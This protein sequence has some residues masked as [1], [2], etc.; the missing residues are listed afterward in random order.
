MNNMRSTP[1]RKSN[2]IARLAGQQGARPPTGNQEGVEKSATGRNSSQPNEEDH[3]LTETTSQTGRPS[4]TN[5]SVTSKGTRVRWTRDEYRDVMRTYYTAIHHPSNGP[6]T[7]NAYLIWRKTNPNTRLN[8][9]ENKL[10][11]QR[12]YIMNKKIFTED[13]LKEIEDSVKNDVNNNHVILPPTEQQ[14]EVNIQEVNME[15]TNDEDDTNYQPEATPEPEALEIDENELQN[16]I[17]EVIRR[18]EEMKFLDIEKR[19]HLPKMKNDRKTRNIIQKVNA[20]VK[21]IRQRYD[22]NLDITQ[23]NNIMFAAAIAAQDLAGIKV[24]KRDEGKRKRKQ[25]LWKEKI[26]KSIDQK[27]KDLSTLTEIKAGKN[28]NIQ[29]KKKLMKIYAIKNNDEIDNV[30]ERL[31]QEIQAKAQRIR[32]YE[33]RSKFYRQ[34]KL[35]KQD[36]KKFYRELGKKDIQ[37]KEHPK[38]EEIEFFWRKIMED[39]KEHNSSA[40]WIKEQEEA[41]K[42]IQTQEWENITAEEINLAI[43]NSSNWKSPGTDK[44]PNFWIKMISCM[45]QDLATAYNDIIS[46]PEKT[47]EWLTQGTT[48]LLPKSDETNLPKNYRPITCLPTMYKLLTSIITER[49]YKFLEEQELL[50]AEQKGC[51]RG[52]YGCKDQL[53]VNKMILEHCKKKRNPLS[54]A[55]VDYKKA[56]DSVPHT[57][58]IKCMEI[59]KL[60]PKLI[61]FMKTSMKNW[62]TTMILN[63]ETPIVTDP[64]KIKSGIFQGDSFSPLIFCLALAP[65]SFMLNKSNAGYKVYDEKINHLFYMDDL[66]LYAN[67]DKN[68]KELLEIVKK[69][70]DDIK[71]EFGLDKCAKATFKEGKLKKTQNIVLAKDTTIKELENE[72]T[73]KYLGVEESDGIPHAKMKEKIRKEYYRRIRLV[74]N[75]ELNSANKM[76]AINT[77]AVPV[78]TYSFNIINWTI[79]DI[80]RLDRKTRKLLT[81]NRMHHPKADVDRIYVPRKE[82]GRGLLQLLAAYKTTTIGLELYLREKKD[83]FMKAVLQHETEKGVHSIVKNAER[84]K[85]DLKRFEIRERERMKQQPKK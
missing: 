18:W 20:A 38:K 26:Q 71:M 45:H 14:P 47:P 49:T 37:I 53:L 51:K 76:T 65:L 60:S 69:F 64:I 13:E 32:R 82:G 29:K 22:E 78:V 77:L 10:A 84:F 34:N 9:D 72:E 33:K 52:S 27:R 36:G 75:S 17:D 54:T 73:Y 48:Y 19:Q 28:V 61:D 58:I 63:A 83:K 74:L 80:N 43:R 2:R 41:N 1:V 44:V 6:T 39:D 68:L 8:I 5:P 15:E 57:W 3:S 23:I 59:F 35:F 66:K 21:I 81:I 30:R 12:R 56:F 55:W 25:P 70:S 16:I 46:A 62:Q 4:S 79:E 40:E 11:T 7:K 31:K 42:N 85:K 67:D 24:R 50:P